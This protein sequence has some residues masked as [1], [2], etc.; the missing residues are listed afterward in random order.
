MATPS[1]STR[2]RSEAASVS[3]V[4]AMVSR[5]VTNAAAGVRM[6]SQTGMTTI[7]DYD[8]FGGMAEDDF[9]IL[10]APRR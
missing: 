2:S 4:D 7:H 6:A 5:T 9:L 3:V 1:K 8:A 10:S